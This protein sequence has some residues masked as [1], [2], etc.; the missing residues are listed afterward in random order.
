[1]KRILINLYMVFL[2][3][4]GTSK[5]YMFNSFLET[6]KQ[7]HLEDLM[8]ILELELKNT[9]PYSYAPLLLAKCL[10]EKFMENNLWSSLTRANPKINWKDY[11]IHKLNSNWVLFPSQSTALKKGF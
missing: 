2:P 11:V 6:G 3:L 8:E 10:L 9:D 1:M 5:I 7:S 4:I